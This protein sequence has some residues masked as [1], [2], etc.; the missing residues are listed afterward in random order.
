MGA[1]RDNMI[2]IKGCAQVGSG[3]KRR[4]IRWKRQIACVR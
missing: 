4:F 2:G 1:R 3:G